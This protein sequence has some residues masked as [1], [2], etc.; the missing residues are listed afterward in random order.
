MEYEGI[1]IEDKVMFRVWD[2]IEENV[3]KAID[4]T[5]QKWATPSEN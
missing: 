4:E 3:Q 2:I 1:R 5:S